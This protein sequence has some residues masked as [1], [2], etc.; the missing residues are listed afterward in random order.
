L[1]RKKV[2]P[3]SFNILVL[4]FILT[5]PLLFNEGEKK[6]KKKKEVNKTTLLLD[7]NVQRRKK[8]K[9]DPL[10]NKPVVVY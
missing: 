2:F 8:K 7:D 3:F 5:F 6:I 4:S 9:T 1:E 10:I